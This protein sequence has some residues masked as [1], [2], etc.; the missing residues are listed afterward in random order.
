MNTSFISLKDIAAICGVSLSTV[1]KALH[2]YPDISRE[3]A[4]R[5]QKTASELGYI[6]LPPVPRPPADSSRRIGVLLL[7]NDLT[8]FEEYYFHKIIYSFSQMVS[9]RGY[10]PLLFLDKRN[11]GSASVISRVLLQHPDGLCIVG[12]EKTDA[13]IRELLD[14]TPHII[15][16]D[17]LLDRHQSVLS[18]QDEGIRIL[19]AYCR[20]KGHTR[21]AYFNTVDSFYNRRARDTYIR[22][23]HEMSLPSSYLTNI[24]ISRAEDSSILPKYRSNLRSELSRLL[25]LPERP[26]CILCSDDLFAYACIRELESMDIRVPD[27]ISVAGFGAFSIHMGIRPYLTTVQPF[28]EVIG[29]RAAHDLIDSIEDPAS[30]RYKP[31]YIEPVLVEG[32][33]VKDLSLDKTALLN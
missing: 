29:S 26:S 24:T 22:Y 33:S 8:P 31:V 12:L 14:N 2:D 4:E 19:M 23:A 16:I 32:C 25:S 15:S 17:R 18:S 27:M 11:P 13:A 28:P 9:A 10:D 3:T 7:K 5:I 20:M 21:I 6:K 30:V 1:S